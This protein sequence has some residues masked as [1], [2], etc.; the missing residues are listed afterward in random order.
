MAPDPPRRPGPGAGTLA[1]PGLAQA[2]WP[3]RPITWWSAS[4][5]A[6]R[7]ISPPA[8]AERPAAGA[9]PARDLIEQSR[10]RRRRPGAETVMRDKP[11]GYTLLVGNANLARHRPAHHAVDDLQPARARADRDRCCRSGLIFSTHPLRPGEDSRRN[12]HLGEVGEGRIVGS[13]LGQRRQPPMWRWSCPCPRR[14]PG[15]HPCALSG[16][17]LCGAGPVAGRFQIIAN[18][19]S[20]LHP[21][22]EGE[23]ADALMVTNHRAIPA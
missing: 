12:R 2:P 5:P 4:R 6:G 20:V 14:R 7:P 17:A 3:S 1:G 19:A 9:R 23:A 10:R 11:D 18:G 13:R 22:I 8:S 16:S 15:D 21:F